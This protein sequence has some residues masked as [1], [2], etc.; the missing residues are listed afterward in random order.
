[1]EPSD[2]ATITEFAIVVAGFTG[3]VIAIGSRDG[4][5]DPLVKFR[6]VT[7]MFYAFTAAFGSL[8]PIFGE[9]LGVANAWL[10]SA[11]CLSA[12]LIS[13]IVAT[14]ICRQVLLSPEQRAQLKVWM[15][16]LV[17]G[18]NTLFA[19]ALAL[20]FLGIFTTPASGIVF[21]AL[22]WQLVL[23]TILFTRLIL[24]R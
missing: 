11:A 23:S 1:M 3:L 10:F 16:F 13:N 12:L 9:A 4:T 18:G 19:V 6:A 8:L 24:Q 21:A 14:F 2:T 15:Y 22:I 5:A 20:S 7:M 17:V